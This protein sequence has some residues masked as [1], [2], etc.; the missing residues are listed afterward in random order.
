MGTGIDR[1]GFGRD[2]GRRGI[3]D[4][5]FGAF[6]KR[7]KFREVVK[8]FLMRIC[9]I[10]PTQQHRKHFFKREFVNKILM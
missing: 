8:I 1:R 4:V 2:W 7:K 3:G 9:S 6:L 5:V 10:I